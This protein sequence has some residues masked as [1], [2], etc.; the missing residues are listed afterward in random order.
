MLENMDFALCKWLWTST[1]LKQHAYHS[2]PKPCVLQRAKSM[3]SLKR[4]YDWCIVGRRI[5]FTHVLAVGIFS[6]LAWMNS[7]DGS[8]ENPIGGTPLDPVANIKIF[9]SV[10]SVS[11][12]RKIINLR[13]HIQC[14]TYTVWSCIFYCIL[15]CG[16][17]WREMFI[18]GSPEM[19][20]G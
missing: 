16:W 12:S 13:L 17:T 14:Q 11:P 6:W 9:D 19:T 18:Q 7:R 20:L 15:Y 2:C 5:Q 8:G 10:V 1:W 4:M 3:F